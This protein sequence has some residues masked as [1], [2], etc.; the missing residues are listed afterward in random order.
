ME[1]Q[2]IVHATLHF[3]V[4]EF[5]EPEK[6]PP[7]SP[8]LSPV[9]YSVWGRC[10]RW[11]C[12]KISHM[13]QLN[14]MLIN[15]WAQLSQDIII[16]IIGAHSDQ[17]EPPAVAIVR[18]NG[19]SSASSRASVADT[20]VSRQIWWTQVVDG[21]QQVRLHS[22]EGRSPSLILAQIR[23]IEF[24]GTSLRSLA[25]WPKRPSLR[26]RTMY[27]MSNRP[28]RC[29]TSS[30]DTKSSQLM[31]RMRRWQRRWKESGQPGHDTLN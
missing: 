13:D 27:E 9:D 30:L 28:V 25:T 23:R 11:C 18:Q 6:W 21:R 12:H 31:C 16:I 19:L 4:P 5:T 7:N 29:K 14:C 22:C 10:N 17:P 15:C 26:L 2:H 1:R 3:H 24:A 8:Y 20:P